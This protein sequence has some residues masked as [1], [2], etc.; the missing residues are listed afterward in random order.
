MWNR[1]RFQAVAEAYVLQ[2]V[3]LLNEGQWAGWTVKRVIRS[4][5]SS[6]ID[7]ELES[8]G[9]LATL[10]LTD[11]AAPGLVASLRLAVSARLARLLSYVSRR[12][13]RSV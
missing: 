11:V 9:W 7:V 5:W 8:G 3:E 13:P 1:E 12:S 4:R 2:N 10:R 6:A